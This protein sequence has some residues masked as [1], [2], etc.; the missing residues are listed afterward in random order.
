[1]T[2]SRRTTILVPTGALGGGVRLIKVITVDSPRAV[3]VSY[4]RPKPRGC[5]GERGTHGGQQYVPLL[6]L[7]LA[8]RI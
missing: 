7:E 8:R 3:K 5:Q 4:P 1:M 2:A 6:D